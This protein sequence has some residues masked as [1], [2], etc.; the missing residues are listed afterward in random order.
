M[1]FLLTGGCQIGKLPGEQR[2]P[3]AT[4][5][6]SS[7]YAV[8]FMTL[9]AAEDGTLVAT[10][11]RG[12]AGSAQTQHANAYCVMPAGAGAVPP[13]PGDVIFVELRKQGL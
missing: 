1:L 12:K 5:P 10:P 3:K 6:G 11:V 13:Q 8:K 7:F 2:P 9:K 4:D